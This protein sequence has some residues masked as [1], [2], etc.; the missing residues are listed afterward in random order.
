MVHPQ[1]MKKSILRNIFAGG[2]LLFLLAAL[3]LTITGGWGSLARGSTP[4]IL[5]IDLE[6]PLP[7]TSDSLLAGLGLEEPLSLRG[8]VEALERATHDRRVK[9][10]VARI[11][12]G[13]AGLARYQ[14]LR[15]AIVRFR[16]S[17]K[18]SDRLRGN[19]WRSRPFKR[20]LLSCDR[21]RRNL[22]PA[23]R[24]S[25]S[26]WSARGKP[27]FS[28]DLRQAWRDAARWTSPRIQER[29]QCPHG[30]GV[31]PGTS[32]VARE[33]SCLPILADHWGYRRQA[34]YSRTAAARINKLRSPPRQ[35]RPRRWVCR[36]AALPRRS[37]REGARLGGPELGASLSSQVSKTR[38][39]CVRQRRPRRGHHRGWTGAA[40]QKR[41]QPPLER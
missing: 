6:E 23:H 29:A 3:Y 13:Q 16:S 21:V 35:R 1:R 39:R 11:N 19:I 20:L 40:R 30:E 10:L 18:T 33:P 31:H 25:R 12:A 32:R 37:L 22:S 34:P 14:E 7:E 17:G 2:A 27:V 36:W 26:H 15:D 38:G 5:E 8:A 41:L 28:R 9:V 24:R 4:L